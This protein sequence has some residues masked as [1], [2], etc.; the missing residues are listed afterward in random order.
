M[1]SME[2][3]E[4][5]LNHPNGLFS[6]H[7]TEYWKAVETR[8]SEYDG[9]FVFGVRSTGIYCRPSC[10]AKRAHRNQVVFFTLPDAAE[11]AG[12]RSCRRCHP[13]SASFRNPQLD[14]VQHI[15]RWIESHLED[16][17]TLESISKEMGLSSFHLQ[18]TFKRFMGITPRQYADAF[19]LRKF[20][21]TLK[22][23]QSVTNALYEAGYGSN[24][25]LY[26]RAS[27]QLGMTPSVYKK[28]G[29]GIHIHYSISSTS[30]G[31]VLIGATDRGIC[32]IRFGNSVEKLQSE[33]Q[34]EYPEAKITKGSTRLQEWTAFIL[35]Y[36][37]G[38]QK[39]LILPLDIQA[40]T[41]QWKVW[42][43]LQTIPYGTTLS[44]KQVA[45]SI[46]RP[47]AAR[48]VARACATNPVALVIPCHRVVREDG[49]LGGYRW[50]LHRKDALL[51]QEA[52]K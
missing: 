50:G 3:I 47:S 13:E 11:V 24:S 32:S 51:K 46:G 19:R 49:N 29:K 52:I 35:R 1:K 28:G 7:E 8:D 41:F 34:K 22:A 30:I 48:A 39:E 37:K 31:K 44:Y 45:K 33:L 43:A 42:K 6:M 5:G 20:K 9:A 18:R 2:F 25:R 36:L 12:F 23:G 38:W 26:E 17:L 15:C 21:T 14:A 40:T 4:P 27:S 16:T 10:P